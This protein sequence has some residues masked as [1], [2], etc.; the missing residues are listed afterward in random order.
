M[1]AKAARKQEVE[2]LKKKC[3]EDEVVISEQKALVDDELK[4][5]WPEVEAAQSA[6]GDLK[7]ENLNE[8]RNYKVPPDAVQDVLSAVLFLMGT[9]DTTWASMKKFLAQRGIVSN[10]MNYDAH[11]ITPELRNAV[12]KIIDKK[13]NSFRP[14]VIIKVSRAVAPLAAWVI[15]NVKY[16]KVLLRIEPL[17]KQM[18]ALKRQL[19]ESTDRASFCEQQLGELDAQT[20][21]LNRELMDKTAQA[22]SLKLDLKTAEDTLESAQKLLLQL[23]GEKDRWDI[24]VAEIH[25]DLK[26]LPIKSLLSASYIT[27]LGPS[28]EV[29]REKKL[30]EWMSMF[31]CEEFNFMRFMESESTLLR[32][33]SEGLPADEL[34]MENAIMI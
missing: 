2:V 28:N 6:V 12:T 14:D 30:H 20:K 1:E 5:I 34:S 23:S 26:L 25:D 17:E 13:K 19:K 27:Y 24:Q 9:K 3:Q 10:I 33:K 16:S 32:Y 22:E 11:N 7:S 29:I 4:D 21:I 8:V 31:K 18:K 15:A